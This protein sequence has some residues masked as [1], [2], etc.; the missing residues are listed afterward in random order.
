[1][2]REGGQSTI[3]SQKRR[4]VNVKGRIQKYANCK[5]CMLIRADK[6]RRINIADKEMIH[7]CAISQRMEQS[8]YATTSFIM[9]IDT[10]YT[11]FANIHT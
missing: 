10:M 5:I 8:V 6:V 2:K 9:N 4:V 1:M 11:L 3:I 7:I